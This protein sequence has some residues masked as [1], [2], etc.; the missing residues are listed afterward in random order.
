MSS[1]VSLAKSSLRRQ[2]KEQLKINLFDLSAKQ[3]CDL[4]ILNLANQLMKNQNGVWALFKARPDEPDLLTLTQLA[5]HIT[6]VFP[7]IVNEEMIFRKLSEK[8]PQNEHQW[9]V[10]SFGIYEPTPG[11]QELAAQHLDGFLV[12]GLAYD[13]QGARLG[14]GKGY[15]DKALAT[16]KAPKWGVAYDCQTFSEIPNEEHDIKMTGLIS[17]KKLYEINDESSNKIKK[18]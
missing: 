17:E 18:S 9:T 2:V 10:G 4:A 14:R 5:S 11:G 6:W 16:S 7:V 1:N 13:Y 3:K 8:T 12:P 15:Y